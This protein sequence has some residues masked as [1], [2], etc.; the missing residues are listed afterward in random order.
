MENREIARIL[1]DTAQLLEID[2]AIIGRYR[3]YERAAELI[4][5]LTESVDDLARDPEKADRTARRRRPPGRAHPGNPQDRRLRPAQETAQEISR[6]DSRP[7]RRAIAGP[8]EGRA[9][10]AQIQSR[11]RGRRRK[12]RAR[13][14]AARSTRVRRKNRREHPQS[15]RGTQENGRTL[16]AELCG[17]RSRQAGRAHQRLRQAGRVGDAGRL[18]APR[19][20]N[21]RRPRS[22]GH[23]RERASHRARGGRARRSTSW[24]TEKSNRCWRTAKTK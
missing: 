19:Q 3:S 9:A 12:T 11:H 22:A 2:G 15:D 24:P 5:S 14:K 6:N 10:L 20:G 16:P 18:A 1:R 7:A 21:G 8:E 13:G 4:A 23:V 17:G